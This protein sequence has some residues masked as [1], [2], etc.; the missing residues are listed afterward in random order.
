[1]MR[2]R[3][4][5]FRLGVP[6]LVCA[7]LVF[8]VVFSAGYVYS[9]K[10]ILD[11]AERNARNLAL[12]VAHR[13]ESVLAP[14]EKLPD[15][16]AVVLER[17]DLGD[18]AMIGMLQ[19]MLDA[20]THVFGSAI[21]FEPYAFNPASLYYCPYLYRNGGDVEVAYLGGENYHYFY[22]DWYQ[23]PRE[24]QRPCWSEPYFDENGGNI[25][26]ATYTRPFFR[27][28]TGQRRFS[29]VI[30]AD[31]SLAWLEKT[32][33]KVPI[34]RTG[35]GFILSQNGTFIT[36]PEKRWVM[37]ES[38]FSI[39]EA[40]TDPGLRHLGKQ[41]IHGK[42]GFVRFSG[43]SSQRPGFLYFAPIGFSRWSIGFF[44]PQ[45]ELMAHLN[46]LNRKG[47]FLA[48]CGVTLLVLMVWLIAGTITH[49]LKTL[50]T[51]ARQM[52]TGD[53]EVSVPGLQRGGEVG[54]LAD[55]LKYMRDSLKTHIRELLDTTAAKQRIEGEL[56]V[57]REIQMGLLPKI[58]P[59]FPDIPGFDLFALLTPAREVGGDLYDF[60]RID[61]A[62]ICFVVGDV[63]G[64]GVPASLFMAVTMT[65]IK[66]TAAKGYG[67]NQILREV[68]D[69]LSR[70]NEASMFVT[71]FC[72]ILNIRSGEL[73]YANGGHNPP[74][75]LRRQQPPT[76]LEGT[77]GV[78][79][80][81]ME[82]LDYEMKRIVLQ[83]GDG[84]FLY[85]DGVTEAMDENERL[86]S[87][88]RLCKVLANTDDQPS[89]RLIERVMQSVLNF[90][91]SAPQTDDITMMMIRFR[92]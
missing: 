90:A 91:G 48:I 63:S 55:S 27:E 28:N 8:L 36:H 42:S 58:F 70:D 1:M 45:D 52:A 80:G 64:K 47:I 34:L 26:M 60:Y 69:Q 76:F 61:D 38:I 20:H 39:A 50:S 49:P 68:N 74:L 65:L 9:R 51:A 35:Y 56:N 24:T 6:V 17:I 12:R 30:T 88:E 29:G 14:V 21:A 89:K 71:L 33:S 73:C 18:T 84:L 4:I 66:M 81:A 3:G 57:A 92:R 10:A 16:L 31:I 2:K 85:S 37:N 77:D 46:A 82:N 44:F 19:G 59:P 23:I 53:L 40:R 43:D 79:L 13:V 25:L 83:P 67:P 15:D 75:L 32:L 87:E 22:Q 62:H 5:A 78:L 54:V 86:Y 72:G 41:M 7:S 11:T